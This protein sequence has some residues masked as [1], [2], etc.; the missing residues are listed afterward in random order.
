MGKPVKT[1]VVLQ[2]EVTE[3]GAACLGTVLS[4]YHCHV[5]L[6]KLREQCGVSRDGSKAGNILRAARLYKFEAKG[7][8]MEPPKVATEDGPV[9]VH[10]NFNHFVVVEGQ[11][12]GKVYLNDPAVGRYTV[13]DEEFD[14]A[15]TG[16]VLR[17]RPTEESLIGGPKPSVIDAIRR[18]IRGAEG[19]VGFLVLASLALVVPGL[20][21][22]TLSRVFVD[23]VLIQSKGDWLR[24]L[25]VGMAVT[26]VA[27]GALVWMKERYLLLFFTK[28]SVVSSAKF[29]WHVL[30]LPI[31][32]FMARY[33]GDIGDRVNLNYRVAELLSGRL[34]ETGLDLLMI[35][36]YGALLLSYDVTLTLIGVGFAVAN[37]AVLR[38]I[39]QRRIDESMAVAQEEG[40]LAGVTM[41]GLQVIE[42]IKASGEESDFFS[43]W[44]G[45][46]AK[47]QNRTQALGRSTLYLSSAPMLLS[48]VNSAVVLTLGGVRV[49]EGTMTIGML[50]AYQSLMAS[51]MDPV[52]GLVNLGTTLHE[53]EADMKRLDDVLDHQRAIDAKDDEGEDGASAVRKLTGIVDLDELSFGYAPYAPPLLESFTLNLGPGSRVALVGG[54]GSGKSTVAKLVAGLY[55]PWSGTVRFDRQP[56]PKLGRTTINNSVAMVDQ[57]ISLFEGSV[58]ENLTLWDTSVPDADLFRAATD[59]EIHDDVSV[60]PGGYDSKVEEGGRNFSGGQRQRLEIARAL[61]RNPTV[62]I[63]DEATSALDPRTE[64]RID[65]NLRRRGCTCLIIAHRLSTIRDCDEIVVL[66]DGVVVQRGTHKDLIGQEGRYAQLMGAA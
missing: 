53:A 49:I 64:K 29:L 30:R 66:D 13:T 28:L 33:P 56:R 48:S 27:R 9:I 15:F 14:E 63:L 36:F 34:A 37:L 2:M 23:D 7:F 55:E 3:C 50:V 52:N 45:Y 58:R 20:A 31:P 60:R 62:L 59:A 54:S 5:P 47:F 57:D 12:R 61:V 26:A 25:L 24:P 35:V 40:K 39:S 43:R 21:I 19:T 6:E 42:T 46:W 4:Y 17:I 51:F 16:V 1:P 22:P 8:R 18:R 32:F 10:W 11:R 41:S 65:D 38:T 44:A